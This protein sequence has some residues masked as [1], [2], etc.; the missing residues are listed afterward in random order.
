ME[1]IENYINQVHELRNTEV[2]AGFSDLEFEELQSNLYMRH[3]KKGQILF[4]EGDQ[5]ERI[6]FLKKGLVRLERY[7]ASA[8]FSYFDYVKTE[9]LFPYGGMFTDKEY[10]YSAYAVTDIDLYYIPM[11]VFEKVVLQNKEQMIYICTRLSKLLLNHEVRLQ[12]CVTSSATDRVIQTIG[13]LM[14]KLG[15]PITPELI[16]IPYPITL[17]ELASLSGTTRETVGHTMKKL[18]E[19]QKIE[20]HHKIFVFLDSDYFKDHL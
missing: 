3:Y 1:K 7:D 13:I 17:K 10:H 15:E 20:Y 6:Y 19:E 5:R 4:D 2:F 11:Q 12:N 16:E 8:T 14:D 18:K 9:R